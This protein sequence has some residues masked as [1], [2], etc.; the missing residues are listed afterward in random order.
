MSTLRLAGRIDHA[1]I[2]RALQVEAKLA[3]FLLDMRYTVGA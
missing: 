3:G 1:A 2:R